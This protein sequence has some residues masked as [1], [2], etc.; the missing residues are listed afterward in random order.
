MAVKRPSILTD[1]GLKRSHELAVFMR[2][3]QAGL[4]IASMVTDSPHPMLQASIPEG[5]GGV[6]WP[7]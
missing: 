6:L 5:Q 7:N 3:Y 1:P 4:C 2:T